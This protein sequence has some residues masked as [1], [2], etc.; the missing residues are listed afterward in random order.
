MN[1]LPATQKNMRFLWPGALTLSMGAV[2]FSDSVS[3]KFYIGI[4]PGCIVK[5]SA[6]TK[7]RLYFSRTA[8]GILDQGNTVYP[9]GASLPDDIP[10]R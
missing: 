3:G 1:P 6:L 4:A 8:S 9:I 2:M 5:L 10:S 7:D